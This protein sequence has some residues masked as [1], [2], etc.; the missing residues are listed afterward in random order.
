MTEGKDAVSKDHK[1]AWESKL[2]GLQ[3]EEGLLQKQQKNLRRQDHWTPRE[4]H[5]SLG[6]TNLNKDSEVTYDSNYHRQKHL[7]K[8]MVMTLVGPGL[9]QIKKNHML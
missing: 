9:Q 3:M 7:L 8:H 1:D 4:I 6:D 5:H 2:K